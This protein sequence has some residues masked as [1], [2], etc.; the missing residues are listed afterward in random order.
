MLIVLM[1][2]MTYFYYAT[3]FMAMSEATKIKLLDLDHLF[4]LTAF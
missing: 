2:C 3:H 1:C 4:K